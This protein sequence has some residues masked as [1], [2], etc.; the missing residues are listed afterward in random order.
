MRPDN[1]TELNKAPR[2]TRRSFSR[3]VYDA[4]LAAGGEATLQ[5]VVDLVLATDDATKWETNS[6][7]R[8][9]EV[10][11]SALAHGYLVHDDRKRTWL[12]AP[13]SYY[14]ERQEYIRS[15]NARSL[16]QRS[17][18]KQSHHADPE[19]Y[20]VRIPK[21]QPHAVWALLFGIVIGG[22]STALAVWAGWLV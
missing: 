18:A 20:T 8:V 17:G 3:S 6:P 13:R 22:V 15:N 19:A 5:E 4:I 21:P 9:T 1:V 12:I 2:P 11:N 16:D 14:E 10:L 7:A